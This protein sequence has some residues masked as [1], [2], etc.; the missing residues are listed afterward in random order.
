MNHIKSYDIFVEA[1]QIL[2]NDAPNLKI[3]KTK[4]NTEQEQIDG[5]KSLKSSLDSIYKSTKDPVERNKKVD[6]LLGKDNVNKYAIDYKMLL[7]DEYE[8]EKLQNSILSDVADINADNAL[9]AASSS[10][11]DNKDIKIRIRQQITERNMKKSITVSKIAKLKTDMDKRKS[12]FDKKMQ[13]NIK[14][15]NDDIKNLSKV[16][17]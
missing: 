6:D 10:T 11:D 5:F 7:N 16:Q 4:L 2:A 15:I 14:D 17:K 8:L 3:S 12:D 9:L 13:D 1:I